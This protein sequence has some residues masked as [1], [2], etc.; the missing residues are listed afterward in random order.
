MARFRAVRAPLRF[1]P[2][3]AVL[4]L[5]ACTAAPDGSSPATSPG[6]P[7]TSPGPGSSAGAGSVEAASSVLG[8]ASLA[9]GATLDALQALRFTPAGT[10]AAGQLLASGA[11]GDVLWAATYVYASS[12]TD[13]TP[14][15]AIAANTNASPSIR[16]MAGA[17]LVGAGQVAG[18]EP[19]IAALGGSDQMDGAAPAG[20]IWEFSATV[21]ERYT[22][23]GFGPGLAA[24][25]AERTAI[26]GQWQ[27]WLEANRA[28]LRFDA[29]SS[30]WVTA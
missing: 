26:Q 23:A 22:G 2:L 16:A 12:N 27:S 11:T 17:G 4:I 15:L 14:L 5:S 25:D 18:F 7:G 9:D 21:L 24:T 29:P 28:S 13:P 3:A 19:L 1:V 6:L 20:F 30:L 10:E 8:A